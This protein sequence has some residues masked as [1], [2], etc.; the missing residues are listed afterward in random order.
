MTVGLVLTALAVLSV[1]GRASARRFEACFPR[2]RPP[3]R[4]PPNSLLLIGLVC[5]AALLVSGTHALIACG[6]ASM[7]LRHR[8]VR[9]RTDRVHQLE[10]RKLLDGLEIL[11]GELRVGAHPAAACEAAAVECSGVAAH[12]FAVAAARSR[13]GGSAA[14]GIRGESSIVAPEFARIAIAWRVAEQHGLALAELLEAARSDLLG[15]L[16]F[17]GRTESALAGARATGAV[18]AGL[19]LLGLVLGQLMGASPLRVLLG[20]GFGG[21]LL[22]A[23]TVFAC[24]GLLWTDAI[25]G[26]VVA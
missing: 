10:R 9:S 14:S 3:R 11:I 17:R 26:R 25:T 20:G 12:T 22:I 5:I 21:A 2:P 1:P 8:L 16:R 7:T 24:T 6:I 23:G 18:L 15:R 4:L 13:L 19:P